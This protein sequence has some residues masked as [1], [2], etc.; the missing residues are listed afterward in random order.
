MS[1]AAAISWVWAACL[2][3]HLRT[4]LLQVVGAV[5][6]DVLALKETRFT[7]RGP[8]WRSGRRQG[9]R[10]RDHNVCWRHTSRRSV[11]AM[12]TVVKRERREDA[13]R[14]HFLVGFQGKGAYC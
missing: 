11:E 1:P 14:L 7:I 12:F 2:H 9:F 10:D 5:T 8:E 6:G 4:Y 3:T 13:G